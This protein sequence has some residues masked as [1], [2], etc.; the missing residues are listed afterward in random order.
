MIIQHVSGQQVA[1]LDGATVVA[2]YG[3]VDQNT[4]AGDLARM[5][6]KVVCRAGEADHLRERR[7][8]RRHLDRLLHCVGGDVA[9]HTVGVIHVALTAPAGSWLAAIASAVVGTIGMVEALRQG[10]KDVFLVVERFDLLF[11]LLVPTRGGPD[12]CN[13]DVLDGRVRRGDFVGGAVEAA[14]VLEGLF[15][16]LR[17]LEDRRGVSLEARG[18]TRD[19]VVAFVE[20]F[21]E[22]EVY[23]VDHLVDCRRSGDVNVN[24]GIGCLGEIIRTDTHI[25]SHAADTCVV[26]CGG[27]LLHH[28]VRLV[29][30]LLR[31]HA[32][33]GE[34]NQLVVED[35]NEHFVLPVD[36]LSGLDDKSRIR[37]DVHHLVKVFNFRRRHGG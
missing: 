21:V 1:A 15:F 12:A 4:L 13:T 35:V 6:V 19:G 28:H 23:F 34:S 16:Q 26:H 11:V 20:V 9:M 17:H 30:G 36:E 5:L 29:S 27:G 24:V 18:E 8:S 10:S 32:W 25:E 14:G 2:S 33:R 31:G 3:G 7:A 22:F 37:V